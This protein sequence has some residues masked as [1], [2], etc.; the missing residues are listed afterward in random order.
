VRP[1]TLASCSGEESNQGN[2]CGQHPVKFRFMSLSE[3]RRQ[4]PAGFPVQVPEIAAVLRNL[5]LLASLKRPPQR[6]GD[7]RILLRAEFPCE[8]LVPFADLPT[9]V[10]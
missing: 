6:L 2:D 5:R 1:R 10:R 9:A 8:A 3:S 7:E 4:R